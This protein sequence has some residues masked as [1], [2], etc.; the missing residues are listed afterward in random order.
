MT[1]SSDVS[2]V[3]KTDVPSSL[4]ISGCVMK[5]AN[6][7][8][9]PSTSKKFKS[10][11][12]SSSHVSYPQ[13]SKATPDKGNG[14][15]LD[16]HSKDE[17]GPEELESNSSS[18]SIPSGIVQF[19]VQRATSWEKKRQ[20][21]MLSPTSSTMGVLKN[22][23]CFKLTVDVLSIKDIALTEGHEYYLRYST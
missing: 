14:L 1:L 7:L 3:K 23:N 15:S 10:D 19:F 17:A 21:S 9:C 4:S 12:S 5:Q 6:H 2:I 18:H 16:Y 8:K 22:V 13:L 11:F 20:K